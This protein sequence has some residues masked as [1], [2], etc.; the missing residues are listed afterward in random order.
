MIK[1]KEFKIK[2]IEYNFLFQWKK[3]GSV[4]NEINNPKRYRTLFNL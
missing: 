4:L 1:G 2:G 3:F